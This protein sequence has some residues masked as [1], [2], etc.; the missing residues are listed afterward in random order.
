[1]KQLLAGFCALLALGTAS[2]Q[3]EALSITVDGMFDDWG[4]AAPLHVDPQGDSAVQDLGALYVANDD[5]RLFFRLELN[6]ETIF[7]NSPTDPAGNDLLLYLDTDDSA[8]TG[9]VSRNSRINTALIFVNHHIAESTVRLAYFYLILY[10]NEVTVTHSAETFEIAFSRDRAPL[11]GSSAVAFYFQV[12]SSDVLPDTGALHYSFAAGAAEAEPI[13]LERQNPADVRVLS[14][15]VRNDSPAGNPAPFRR[16]L[17]ATRPD[18]VNFQEV[19]NWDADGTRAFVEDALGGDWFA[20]KVSDCVTVS[21]WPLPHS[22]ASNGNLVCLVDLP[23]SIS[24]RDMV[25]INAHTPCCSNNDGRDQEHDRL[26]ST[27]RGLMEGTGRFPT[28]GDETVVMVGDFNMV[29]FVRQL[30]TLRDGDIISEPE[31]GPDFAPAREA[32]SLTAAPLRHT[33]SRQTFTWA[34]PYG[35]FAPGRLDYILVGEDA[36]ALKRNYGLY[37]PEMPADTLETHGLLANDSLGSDHVPLIA[38]LGFT[39]EPLPDG[40]MLY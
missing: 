30:H 24:G 15:N 34:N 2:V 29:G 37:T 5:A 6:R 10:Q 31:Y 40:V 13:P 27:W 26:S 23:P 8:G 39:P 12:G 7:Q 3:A 32:G 4:Q 19:Y 11:Q 25:L 33:N 9:L 35:A 16:I 17:Q 38:D 14:W 1:M 21:R 18:I 20:T 22:A 36:A 28:R